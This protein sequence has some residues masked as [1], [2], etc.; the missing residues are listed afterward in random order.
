MT[1]PDVDPRTRKVAENAERLQR[2]TRLDAWRTLPRRRLLVVAMLAVLAAIVTLAWLDL[3]VPMLIAL[4]LALSVFLFLRRVVRGMADL[5]DELVDERVRAVRN[6]RYRV[7]FQAVSGVTAFLLLAGYIAA[8]SSRLAWQ[9]EARHLHAGF[10]WLIV[11]S[12]ALPTMLVAWN[13]REV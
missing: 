5:P 12:L 2:D 13:E 9:P 8:D 1:R 4:A 3:G 11:S 7:A 6:E 10:W